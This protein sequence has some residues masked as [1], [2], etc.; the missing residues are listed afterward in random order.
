MN[1]C[2]ILQFRSRKAELEEIA[3][4][5]IIKNTAKYLIDSCDGDFA[6]VFRTK[7]VKHLF[8]NVG[9]RRFVIAMSDCSS[10]NFLTN[11]WDS[12]EFDLDVR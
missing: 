9:D 8:D 1:S 12:Q 7:D 4:K 6:I 3:K 5:Q 11:L 2:K 10:G